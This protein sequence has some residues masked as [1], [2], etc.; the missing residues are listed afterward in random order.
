MLAI[1]AGS[2]VSEL[3]QEPF[4]VIVNTPYGPHSE[5]VHGKLSYED[6]FVQYRHNKDHSI[7]PHKINFRAN[8]FALKELGV[9][10]IV[11]CCTVGSLQE[12]YKPGMIVIPD[13][14]INHAN[15]VHTFYNGPFVY[16]VSMADP[17]CP[18]MRNALIKSCAQL[19]V[20]FK[21]SGTYLRI[22]GPQF[23]TK[24]ASRFYRSFADMIGMTGV[25]EAILAREL[26]MCFSIVATITDYDT[27]AE[28]TVSMEQIK[29]TM[30]QNLENL[31]KILQ[32]A[33]PTMQERLCSCK[34]S[35]EG[36][37]A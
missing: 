31:Q 17:F 34:N 37:K 18:R 13:Q 33:A 8:I 35:L 21:Q 28:R 12:D 2:G 26:G 15:D 19:R 1:I 36:A 25:P 4:P 11:S 6:V 24:A 20:P 5:I 10:Q 16:H 23:S 3:L 29:Q 7:P 32:T 14:F 30:K 27:F 9:D 22:A